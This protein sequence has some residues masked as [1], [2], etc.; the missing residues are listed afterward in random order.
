MLRMMNFG[1]N[2]GQYGVLTEKDLALHVKQSE[3]TIDNQEVAS[4][5]DCL[6]WSSMGAEFKKGMFLL[7]DGILWVSEETGELELISNLHVA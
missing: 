5:Y 7:S 3:T 6:E 4:Y 2:D 1:L